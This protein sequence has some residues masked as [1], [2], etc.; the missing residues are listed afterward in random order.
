MSECQVGG[1]N[2]NEEC[3]IVGRASKGEYQVVGHS[4]NLPRV[5]INR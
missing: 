2:F 3:Q 1:V 4:M 5:L